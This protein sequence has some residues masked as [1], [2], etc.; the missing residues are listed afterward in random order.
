MSSDGSEI[1]ESISNWPIRRTRVQQ[2]FR[3]AVLLAGAAL[4]VVLVSTVTTAVV[5]LR[6]AAR[7]VE[8]SAHV[9][10][11]L[12][13]I[14][15]LRRE[16]RELAR[17]GRR[18]LLERDTNEQ[19]RASGHQAE[20]ER[21]RD[22]LGAET[23]PLQ[24]EID[25]Y[26]S[27][28]VRAMSSD[29]SE[30]A[31][32]QIARFEVDLAAARDAL[33]TVFGAFAARERSQLDASGATRRLVTRA[34]WAL[35]IAG[36][37]RLVLVVGSVIAVERTASSER[38]A[39]RSATATSERAAAARKELLAASTHLRSPLE[40]I[41]THSR[42]LLMQT[43]SDEERREL[44]AIS[45]AASRVEHLLSELLDVSA[46]QAGTLTLQ[47]QSC[48][49]TALIDDAIDAHRDAARERGIRWRVEARSPL[50]VCADHGRVARALSTLL[51]LALAAAR[52]GAEIVVAATPSKDGVRFMVSDASP[53]SL[54][55]ELAPSF[56]SLAAVSDND[57]E[58]YLCKRVVEAHG[59][60]VGIE[61]TPAGQRYW[62][63]LPTEPR[64]LMVS[65]RAGAAHVPGQ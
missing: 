53:S 42:G 40:V 16:A 59:G 28:I 60:R 25:H 21:G 8:T 37:F 11:R 38:R 62:L 56:E 5:A 45:A 19:R 43:R 29:S 10:E 50:L 49:A 46:V 57:L 31:A 12:A 7:R 34:Q 24:I 30:D 41:Q 48:E 39:L 61:A 3:K 65:T 36:L 26:V 15:Q 52:V 64:L 17:S 51:G 20:L 55:R 4:V 27:T 1:D 35:L 9:H 23:H 2:K 6:S 13:V 54:P 63:T 18:F 58:L 22:R 33:G 32:A 47:R 14:E 44:Q